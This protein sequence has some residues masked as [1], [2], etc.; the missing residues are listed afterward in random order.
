MI[1][2]LVVS[3]L[4]LHWRLWVGTFA[5]LTAGALIA[6]VCAGDLSTARAM[7]PGPDQA[8]LLNH[9][10]IYSTM[11]GLIVIG[12]L[13]VVIGFAVKLQ[14]PSH[15]LWQIAGLGP[16]TVSRVVVLQTL[17]LAIAA[18]LIGAA[19]APTIVSLFLNDLTAPLRAP[20]AKPYTIVIAAD[21]SAI[22]GFVFLIVVSVTAT[23]ASIAAR[24]VPLLLAVRSEEHD[25]AGSGRSRWRVVVAIGF[26]VLAAVLMT[27][28]LL[29]DRGVSSLFPV[30]IIALAVTVAPWVV[31]PVTDTWTRVVPG[32]ASTSW[33]LARRSAA[34]Q[35]ARSHATI[36]MLSFAIMLGGFTGGMGLWSD[37]RSIEIAI[38]LFGAPV[39]IVLI[40]AGVTVSMTFLD[41]RREAAL[42]VVG[43]ATFRTALLVAAFESLICTGTAAIVGLAALVP[44]M[45]V[46]FGGEPWDS[47]LVP[48]PAVLTVGCVVLLA[49]TAAP[50]LAASRRP[51]AEGVRA[52][53]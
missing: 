32:R 21:T 12:S 16:R 13:S 35:L 24:R 26:A 31:G 43:G 27:A 3:D 53:V 51:L 14:R 40:T 42:L 5:V 47:V 10:M 22:A 45:I 2:R 34:Y 41:R 1:A 25:G 11:N 50:V 46:P 37:P 6:L 33:S 29:G 44:T 38:A 52:A 30:P 15:A 4:L 19:V 17:L 49:A 9:A 23:F 28:L 39:V 7:P 36:T 48:L 20:G 18:L 8:A